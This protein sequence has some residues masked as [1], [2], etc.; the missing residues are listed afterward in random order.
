MQQ[1]S[2]PLTKLGIM[3]WT[4]NNRT[5]GYSACGCLERIA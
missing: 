4:R 2:G 5:Q 3:L 1:C